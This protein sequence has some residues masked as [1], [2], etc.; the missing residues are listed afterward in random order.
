MFGLALIILAMAGMS[1]AL[2]ITQTAKAL[3]YSRRQ[4]KET[5]EALRHELA[6]RREMVPYI[7]ATVNTDASQL[8]DVIGNACDLADHVASVHE[9]SQAEARLTSSLNRL[10]AFIDAEH[11]ATGQE[12][13]DHLRARLQDQYNRIMMHKEI[14]NRQAE[15]LNTL[16]ERGVARLFVSFGIYRKADLY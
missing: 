9:C 14:Y 8:L 6:A 15:T 10:F 12:T 3:D 1:F 2:W 4:V 13:L 11:D 5:W 16:L 7:V